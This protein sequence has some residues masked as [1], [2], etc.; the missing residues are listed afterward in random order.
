MKSPLPF[1]RELLLGVPRN[2]FSA[3]TQRHIAMVA[4]LAWIGL[5]ADGLS[6]SCYGPEE[7]FL[8]LGTHTHLALYIAIATAVTVFIIA[9]AYNQVIELFPS[10]GGGYK[11]ATQL[12]GP[13]AGLVSGAALIIDYVLTIALSSASGMDA[14]FSLLPAS[15]QHLKLLAEAC[16]L[17]LLIGLNMRG[18]KESIKLLMPIFI[19]FVVIHVILILWGVLS[20]GRD[21]PTV[22][23]GTVH[24][25]KSLAQQMGWMFV[26]ALLLRAYSLGGGTYTGIE[27]VSNNVNRL[28]EPRVQTGKWTM[29]YMTVSLGFTAAGIILLYLLWNVH[30]VEGKTL[31]AVVFHSILGDS[32]WGHFTLI[33][34]LALEAGLLLVAANTGFLAGPT[35]LANMAIDGWMPNRFRHLSSRL[36]TQ[37]GIILFGLAAL[38]ILWWSKGSVAWLVVLYSINVFLTFTLSILGLCVY[39]WRQRR[40]AVAAAV[41]NWRLRLIFSLFAFCVTGG[42]LLVTLFSKFTSGGW[43]TVVVTGAVVSLCLVVKHHY[44]K[45]NAK[46]TNIDALLRTPAS[47]GPVIAPL[48]D[49]EKPTAVFLIGKRFGVGMHSLLWVIRM[50]PGHF[51]NFIFLSAGVVDVENFRG[52]EALGDMQ[53]EVNENLQQFVTYCHSHGIAAEAHSAYGIDPTVQLTELSEKI[54]SKFSNCIF[55]ATKLIFEHENW[56]TRLLHNETSV[57]LQRRLHA[58]NLQLVLLPMRIG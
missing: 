54:A 12:L 52:Q 26:A 9:L 23:S 25:T 35:V 34:A 39:W 15:V 17:L 6:S 22:V 55:F 13:Y 31:N 20:H 33:L 28:A 3:D 51:K 7:A 48:V 42:I 58:R 18:M 19:G 5:G 47:A 49:S 36:V 37:N 1:L 29:F 11:V 38:I 46:L 43:V 53:K 14:L 30:P 40:V 16:L 41:P 24:E 32:Y 10:G 50:F 27:A 8:A 44:S 45:V 57:T 56:W 21:L 2:P 4:F